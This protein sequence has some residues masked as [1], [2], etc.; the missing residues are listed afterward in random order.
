MSSACS[1]PASTHSDA[2]RSRLDT[3]YLAPAVDSASGGGF[4]KL[5]GEELGPVTGLGWKH[6]DVADSWAEIDEHIVSHRIVQALMAI[7]ARDGCTLH[8]AMD[9]F[10]DRYFTLRESRPA[11]FT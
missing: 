11:D 7:R 5:S 8:Q 10:N 6:G 2:H 4:G 3:S 9:V 1:R